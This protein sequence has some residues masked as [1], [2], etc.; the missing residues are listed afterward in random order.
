MSLNIALS[1]AAGSLLTIE[2]QL[3]VASTNISN[4]STVGYTAKSVT[5]ATQM[6][7]NVAQG[8]TSK[9]IT[10]KVD[11]YLQ[12]DLITAQS[13]ASQAS[14]TSS[15]LSSLQSL[16][17][18]VSS[19]SSG[20]DLASVLTSLGTAISTLADAADSTSQ[21]NQVVAQLD[22]TA[23]QLRETSAS[24]Q[25]QRTNAD[26]QIAETVSDANTQ[27]SSIADLN[28]QIRVAQA[29][30]QST[31][32]LEDQRRTALQ[33]LSEDI[34]V[35]SFVDGNGNMQVYSSGGTALIDSTGT[36]HTLS[37]TASSGLSASTTYTGGGISGI[38]LNGTDITNQISSGK[39]KAEIDLRDTTL[40]AVQSELDN[41]AS[42]LA[43]TFNSITNQGSAN[44]PPNSL[45]GTLS[46]SSASAVSVA[47][48]TTVRIA[49]TDANGDVTSSS[50]VDLS[51]AASV[52]DILTKL[53]AV[54]GVSASL[55]GSGNLVIAN[56][57][58]AS[59]GIAVQ[60]TSGSVGGTDLSSYFGLND[61]L[62]GG[63]SA[64]TIAVRSSLSASPSLF[65]AG[66]LSSTLTVG[67][68]AVGASDAT[69]ASK[70][71]SAL[72]SGQSFAAAGNLSSTSSTL[73][74]YAASIISGVATQAKSASAASTSASS[75]LSTLSTTF[76]NQSG[77]NVDQ[78]TANVS[79]L[80]NAYAASAQVMSAVEEMFKSLLTAV[81]SA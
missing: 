57:D 75:T 37:H 46:I 78:E 4:A 23:S 53:N 42:G 35:T 30:G 58:N 70:L 11:Q 79:A 20:D 56:S 60:T 16:L 3:S 64:A 1:S 10:S 81:Q 65:P 39:L 68:A 44:P 18:T 71:S 21:K 48:G 26:Q 40:P 74:D 31:A 49:L 45:T 63:S 5:L 17:G 14:A 29:S 34:G 25:Q 13:A 9:G 6:T 19:S 62:T 77:V 61:V 32:D 66:A 41:L 36:V 2:K 47:S 72:S 73:S 38:M 51:G 33:S 24:V 67:S 52:S 59:G 22:Q 12:R 8:V 55:D 43:T 50:D 80:Q 15:G 76:S 27:L 69:I 54:S 28:K 7:G